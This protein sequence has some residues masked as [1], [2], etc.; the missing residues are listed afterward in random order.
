MAD[1]ENDDLDTERICRF[2]K[3]LAQLATPKKSNCALHFEARNRGGGGGVVEDCGVQK[4]KI[5]S[6]QRSGAIGDK[7]QE[8]Q[9]GI[10]SEEVRLEIWMQTN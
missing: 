8:R 6:L 3:H 10:A 9:V 1:V 7:I 5:Y 2:T 4:V